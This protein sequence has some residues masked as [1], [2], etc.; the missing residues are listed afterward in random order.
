[1]SGLSTGY[2]AYAGAFSY[3]FI[4]FFWLVSCPSEYSPPKAYLGKAPPME[5]GMLA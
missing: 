3:T 1:M 2:C 5:L 4:N